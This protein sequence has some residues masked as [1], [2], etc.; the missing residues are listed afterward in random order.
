MEASDGGK[1]QA[2][3]IQNV[4]SPTLDSY[5]FSLDGFLASQFDLEGRIKTTSTMVPSWKR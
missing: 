2:Q 4:I 3:D 1:S 5:H